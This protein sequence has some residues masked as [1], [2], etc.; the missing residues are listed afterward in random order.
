MLYPGYCN[1][2][3]RYKLSFPLYILINDKEIT[4]TYIL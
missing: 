3:L 1:P 2:G 4:G